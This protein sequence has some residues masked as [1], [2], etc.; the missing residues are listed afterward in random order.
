MIKP[1]N[2]GFL[3]GL[4]I[5][6]ISIIVIPKCNAQ[7]GAIT[8]HPEKEYYSCPSYNAEQLGIMYPYQ[9]GYLWEYSYIDPKYNRI[10]KGISYQPGEK[11][12]TFIS[13]HRLIDVRVKV[14]S[15]NR[16]GDYFTGIIYDEFHWYQ[17][18]IKLPKIDTIKFDSLKVE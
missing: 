1:N 2:K 14:T 8:Y 6:F 12:N 7:S 17:Y 3:I 4:I 13:T 18:E 16:S 9:V 11:A 15:Y 5:L 10:R